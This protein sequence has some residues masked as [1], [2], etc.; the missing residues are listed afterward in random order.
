[1]VS[2]QAPKPDAAQHGDPESFTAPR[3]KKAEDTANGCKGLAQDD[4]DRA[5]AVGNDYMRFRLEQSADAWAARADLLARL[6]ANFSARATENETDTIER[7]DDG[8]GTGSLEQ[9]EAQAEGQSQEG[10]QG[11][12]PGVEGLSPRKEANAD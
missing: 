1:V 11:P 6:E 3:R 12:W 4:R 10:Q 7:T 2:E 5:S 9:G 8:Q